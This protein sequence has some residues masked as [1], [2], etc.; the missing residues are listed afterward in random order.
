M[1]EQLALVYRR[2]LMLLKR[3]VG[4]VQLELCVMLRVSDAATVVDA[5]VKLRLVISGSE[6]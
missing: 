6:G 4:G 1:A 3:G 5:V 2:K